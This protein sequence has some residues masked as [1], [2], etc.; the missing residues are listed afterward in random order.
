MR[1]K[2]PISKPTPSLNLKPSY[3]VSPIGKYLE[4]LRRTHTSTPERFFAEV[5]ISSIPV[6]ETDESFTNSVK[7]SDLKTI[8]KSATQFRPVFVATR[9]GKQ[10]AFTLSEEK[11]LE[12]EK[13]ID[14][15]ANDKDDEAVISI[16]SAMD[17]SSIAEWHKDDGN[18]A[19]SQINDNASISYSYNQ[20]EDNHE[21][22]EENNTIDSFE[23]IEANVPERVSR[24]DSTSMFHNITENPITVSVEVHHANTSAEAIL[25]S[26]ATST[27]TSTLM[28][29]STT[30]SP[31]S[32]VN[33]AKVSLKPRVGFDA[34]NSIHQLSV[35]S[36]QNESS[37]K[38][39]MKSGKW[40]RTIFE[41][42]RNKVTQ[43]KFLFLSFLEYISTTSIVSFQF[44]IAPRRTLDR[45]SHLDSR[46]RQRKSQSQTR[47]SQANIVRRKSI[48]IKDVWPHL[49]SLIE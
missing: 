22:T 28:T 21:K 2:E 29:I 14:K 13:I 44:F 6:M 46:Q 26:S 19:T 42:R 8:D 25:V 9:R 27:S 15:T 5:D 11:D 12:N 39:V 18:V 31:I 36:E 49:F 16:I 3:Y 4:R 37:Q 48:F 30:S 38:L 47:P 32:T 41:A 20:T 43:C 45:N 35:M 7:T 34:S 1:E 17:M 33:Q 24:C 23:M 10:L 40:R